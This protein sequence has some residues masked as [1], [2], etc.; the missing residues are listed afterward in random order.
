LIEL[1]QVSQCKDWQQVYRLFRTLPLIFI[2]LLAG[3]RM[4]VIIVGQGFVFGETQ[5]AV[6][7]GGYLFEINEDFSEVFWPVPAPGHSFDGWTEICKTL[8]GPCELSLNRQLWS[9]DEEIP[10]GARFRSNYAGPLELS[11]YQYYWSESE[12]TLSVPATSIVLSGAHP[13][14]TPRYFMAPPNMSVIIPGERVAGEYR[15]RLGDTPFSDEDFWLFVSSTDTEGRIATVSIEFGLDDQVKAN[16]LKPHSRTTPWGNALAR[17][18]S[19]NN[20]FQL[21]T[22]NN[23][24]FLGTATPDPGVRDIMQRT[25]VSHGWMGQRFS[26]VLQQ[27]PPDMLQLFRGVTAVVI[28]AKIRPAFYTQA[29]GAI[30]LDPQDLWLTPAERNTINWEPDFR[31]GFGSSLNFISAE[32]YL[33]GNSPAWFPSDLYEAWETRSL[34]DI[35]WPVANLLSHELAHANDAMPPAQ[36]G[37]VSGRDTPL[38]ATFR[39]ESES[40]TARLYSTYPLRSNLLDELGGVLFRGDPASFVI[41]ALSPTDVGFEFAQDDANALYAYS[42]PYEDTAMLVEEVLTSYYFGL[43]RMVSFLEVPASQDPSCT[44]YTLRWGVRN[45]AAE[46]AVRER[47]RLVLANILDEADVSRYLDNLPATEDLERGMGLCES[48]ERLSNSNGTVPGRFIAPPELAR[49]Q[50]R[51]FDTHREMRAQ[52]GRGRIHRDYR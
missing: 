34:E 47:A 17:C 42:S 18:A 27:L 19:A 12:Q 38:D 26:Q 20:V 2:L 35:I 8:Y 48:L 46:P 52:A 23:L 3:C 39:A 33:A 5:A 36:L 16:Q 10:L 1:P 28:G 51:R 45:R 31:S 32:L 7:A 44:E 41:Q 6:Y 14:D 24:P 22:L 9:E 37:L 21:C 25:V 50:A 11:N 30:Y 49:I 40:S 4:P 13:A 29:T 15:F 43:N